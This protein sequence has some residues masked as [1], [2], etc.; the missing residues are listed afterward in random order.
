MDVFPA[1]DILGGRCVQLRQG[2]PESQKDFGDPLHCA[3]RWI[4]Q[5]AEALH[6]IN[7][8]GAFGS[9]RKNA[10]LLRLLI[11]E[12]GVTVQLGGGIRS[13]ADAAA[14]LELGVARV[15]L[16]TLA[17]KEPESLSTLAD[18]FGSS[19]VMAG[20]DT[21][22]GQIVINGWREAAGDYIA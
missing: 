4:D 1:V 13:T 7:L 11:Q 16:G 21:R 18:E 9:A 10:D 5:G 3:R 14:W 6:V 22:D 15:I 17:V 19:R 20:V 2:R 8:D 12:T